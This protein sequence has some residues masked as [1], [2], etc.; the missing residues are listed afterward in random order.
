MKRDTKSSSEEEKSLKCGR[1]R[2]GHC[3]QGVVEIPFGF[4][5]DMNIH[6]EKRLRPIVF[7]T[8]RSK[9]IR[10]PAG[11]KDI[12]LLPPRFCILTETRE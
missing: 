6:H 9:D 2:S 4:L 3:W 12:A 7:G 1:S 10:F 8:T 11:H 5:G